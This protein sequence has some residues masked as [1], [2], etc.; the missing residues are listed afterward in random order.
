MK[1]KSSSLATLQK[2][3]PLILLLLIMGL[4]IFFRFWDLWR[5]PPGL[6]PDEAANGLDIFRMFDHHDFRIIYN[7]N[8]PREALFFYLQAIWVGILGNTI[9][10]LRMAAAG[11]GVAAVVMMYFL[12]KDWF[13]RRTALIAA[14][15]MAVN[16]W[17]VII[18]RDG[19]RAGM[20]PLMI[21]AVAFLAGR[22]YKTQR[23][24]YFVLAGI[25]F[26]L[27][28]YTYTAFAL[29]SLVPAVGLL[30]ML[31][32]RRAWLK[33]NLKKLAVSALLAL[34]VLTPLAITIVSHPADST[35]RAGGTSVL[36]HDL[37]GGRPVQTLLSGVGKTLLQYN[38][39]GDK[40]PRHNIPG[41]PLVNTF[42]GIMLILGL[43]VALT[44]LKRLNYS[45]AVAMFFVMMLPAIL[46]AEG[47]PHALR[48]VGTEAGVFLLAAIGVNYLLQRWYRTFPV[49]GPARNIGLA[50]VCALL[51]LT[52]FQGYRAYFVAWAQ[53]PDTYTAYSENMTAIGNYLIVHGSSSQN[54]L[55]AGEYNAKPVE[56]LTHNKAKYDLLSGDQLRNLP[57]EAGSGTKLFIVPAGDQANAELE[58]IKNKFPGGNSSI[59]YSNFSGKPTFYVY[60]VKPSGN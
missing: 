17:V 47:L 50:L 9:A 29:F 34:L 25:V 33:A 2:Y 16:P 35:A 22:A 26:G 39:F 5:L 51:F 48:S 55:V 14:F 24:L 53:S 30:Y 15:L 11:I 56:Y 13:G 40:N 59:Q 32:W 8:G 23:Y 57:L 60:E 52:A 31:L 7:T 36:N 46:T 3:L 41:Q 38:L 28:F 37:N 27:G 44:R 6:H 58:L 49:N 43:V 1:S 45:A 54:Y 10:A 12:A 18:S 42:V 20:T 19:F 4:A 21:A